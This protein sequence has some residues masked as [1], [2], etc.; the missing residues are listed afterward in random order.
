MV[1]RVERRGDTKN[2]GKEMEMREGR[3]V[4]GM[5]NGF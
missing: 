2:D 5:A 1:T 4:D 3:K